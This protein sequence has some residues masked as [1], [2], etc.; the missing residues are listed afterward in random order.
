MR[1]HSAA[2][3]SPRDSKRASLRTFIFP[4]FTRALERAIGA[5]VGA[6]STPATRIEGCVSSA[7]SLETGPIK[8]IERSA[9]HRPLS[10]SAAELTNKLSRQTFRS[11][12]ER[13]NSRALWSRFFSERAKE[14][15]LIQEGHF[16]SRDVAQTSFASSIQT[17]A[18]PRTLRRK[19]KKTLLSLFLPSSK[20]RGKQNTETT[21]PMPSHINGL[22][23]KTGAWEPSEDEAL[24]R[25][26]GEL[27]NR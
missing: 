5:R 23:V 16:P 19:R 26:Q 22:P 13:N 2:P 12:Q 20:Q 4:R 27:G 6:R 21:M 11:R 15:P 9:R 17:T 25:L 10:P 3:A 7:F 14:R 1:N 18:H 24:C 8:K